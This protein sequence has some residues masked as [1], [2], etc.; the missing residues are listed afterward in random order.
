M[1]AGSGADF[2]DFFFASEFKAVQH[3]RNDVGLANGLSVAQ[4]DGVIF[5]GHVSESFRNKGV[6][7]CFKQG[8]Q[9]FFVGDASCLDLFRNHLVALFIPVQHGRE[10]K[11]LLI[12]FSNRE[13]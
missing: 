7:G 5:I 12:W 2:E 1:V 8:V 4:T 6:S 10:I 3:E 13:K 9:Q 11:G